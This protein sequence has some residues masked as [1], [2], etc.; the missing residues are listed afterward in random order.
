MS[1]RKLTSYAVEFKTSSAKLAVESDQS[2]AATARDLGINSVTLH[3]WIKRY[4]P[5][6]KASVNT[7]SSS[8][9]YEELKKLKKEIARVKMER[10][11]LKKAAAYFATHAK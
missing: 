1:K 4:F 7:H 3:G 10:D 2:V 11:I 9:P 6:G 8:N 5:H